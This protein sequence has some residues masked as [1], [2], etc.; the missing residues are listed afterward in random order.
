MYFDAISHDPYESHVASNLAVGTTAGFVCCFGGEV[1]KAPC[2]FL[3]MAFFFVFF[4]LLC[5]CGPGKRQ[6]QERDSDRV[7]I[8]FQN[9]NV[10][11]TSV[12]DSVPNA[13]S[14]LF[15][16]S[17]YGRYVVDSHG[18][19]FKLKA[20]NWYGSHLAKQVPEG[21]DKQPLDHIITLI[22]AWGFNTVRLPYSNQMIHDEK[23]VADADVAANP[24]LKGLRPLEIFD[25]TVAAL[26][27]AG[28]AVILNNHTTFS[29]W[30]CGY[31]NNGLW[32]FS[33]NRAFQQ[34][35]ETWRDDWLFLVDR[36]R[37]VK[38][39]VGADLRNEV[40]TMKYRESILPVMPEWGG[41]GVNDWHY[42]AETV[43]RDINRAN[44]D[45]LIVVEGINWTGMIPT[46]GSGERLHLKR[47]KDLPIHLLFPH[48]LIY[49][50]H[51]YAYIGPNHNGDPKTS[52]GR[53]TYADMT[54]DEL[55]KIIHEEWGYLTEMGQHYT[56]PV[57]ISEFGASQ[58]TTNPKDRAWFAQM[59]QEI[60]ARDLD[61]AYWPLNAEDYG[62]VTPNWSDI[63]SN[64][65]RYDL[66]RKTIENPGFRGPFN[67]D[68]WHGLNIISRDDDQSGLGED[69]FPG[70]RK[71]ACAPGYRLVGLSRNNHGL[72]S[73]SQ[74]RQHGSTVDD[75][76]LEVVSET[77]TRHHGA[78][79]WARGRTKYEC[80][81][82]FYGAGFS[83]HHWGTSGLL[84]RQ[85][86]K[87]LTSTCQTRWFDHGD[88][89]G[90]LSGG[91]W[92]RG[93]WKGQCRENEYIGGVA[94]IDG[95]A[96]ALLCCQIS[97]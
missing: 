59:T 50:A 28:I 32:Y 60:V 42:A 64:D 26:A 34:T 94:H 45:L 35:I 74:Q 29:E 4:G 37:N 39:V 47:V 14:E 19:R 75:Y 88:D 70:A 86:M 65:W 20:V 23:P 51:N 96:S 33:G 38:A 25:H 69:W 63:T 53:T 93:T 17:T 43:G 24:N 56:A 87:P 61:F 8:D 89:R 83:R 27:K 18:S 68:R 54:P 66:I 79:D 21:L 41:G 44:P 31:D 67:M 3:H 58:T 12:L 92:A 84:C 7:A 46:L 15:P 52:P 49:G 10:S 57:W 81:L 97:E 85:S 55:T 82:G 22:Q 2:R 90:S 80:P 11:S 9:F 5:H 48:K 30:C 40:R 78:F 76:R 71:G 91:E 16:L 1:L 73:S 6:F 13:S 62:L 36:Y 95:T 77:Q 72:C